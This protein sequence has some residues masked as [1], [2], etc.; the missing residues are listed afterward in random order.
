[1]PDIVRKMRKAYSDDNPSSP[2]GHAHYE[3]G[4]R[5]TPGHTSR[6]LPDRYK[7]PL[8]ELLVVDPEYLFVSWE[9]P[10]SQLDQARGSLG[11]SAFDNRRLMVRLRDEDDHRR[12][13]ASL[14]LYGEQGRW[15]FG[16]GLAGRWVTAELGFVSDDRFLHLNSAGP[17]FIP[18]NFIIEPGC[19]EELTV[20]YTLGTTG[21]LVI[22]DVGRVTDAPWPD[23]LPPLEGMFPPAPGH[24]GPVRGTD[25][26]APGLPGSR[27]PGLPSS[28]GP[29]LPTSPG[30]PGSPWSASWGGSG[31]YPVTADADTADNQP[32]GDE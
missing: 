23:P 30:L 22:N 5:H 1:M 14:E 2:L 16:H 15:F 31:D 13:A 28:P 4:I 29:G 20:D 9:I 11:Q 27:G 26:D 17:I 18:R 7:V 25:A 24:T 12:I 10:E 21:E 19:F 3:L 6:P 8:F 32:T